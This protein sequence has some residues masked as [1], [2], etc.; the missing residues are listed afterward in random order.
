MYQPEQLSQKELGVDVQ[1]MT[2]NGAGISP[3]KKKLAVV[4]QPPRIIIRL[5]RPNRDGGPTEWKKCLKFELLHTWAS[6]ND[7]AEQNKLLVVCGK[8]RR[9]SERYLIEF[10]NALEMDKFTIILKLHGDSHLYKCVA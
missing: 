10:P 8:E 6:S 4:F 3:S 2:C 7:E 5:I 9:D 1:D